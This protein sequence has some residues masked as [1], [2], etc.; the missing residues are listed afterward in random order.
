MKDNI[1]DVKVELETNEY[2]SVQ[3]KA[4]QQIHFEKKGDEIIFYKL[5]V[6]NKVGIATLK[7]KATCGNQSAYQQIELDVR[8]PNPEMATSSQTIINPSKTES[9]KIDFKNIK[10]TNKAIIELSNVPPIN[11]DQRLTYLIQYPHGCI[12]QT[13][14]SVFPQLYLGRLLDIDI[15]SQQKI[16]LNIK[17]AIQRI[18]L[19]QT[20]SGGFSYWP[21]ESEASEYGSNYAG[22]FL[23]EAEKQGYVIPTQLKNKWIKYQ[24]Q[25]AKNWVQNQYGY[26]RYESNELIQAYRLYTLTLCGSADLASMNRLR[27][28]SNICAAAKSL[29]ALAYQQIGQVE[30]AKQLIASASWQ[31]KT[32][33][34]LSYSYGSDVRDKAI[35]LMAFNKLKERKSIEKY[36][37][38]LAV[39]LNSKTWYS[40]QETAYLLLSLCEF[41]GINST[42]KSNYSYQLNNGKWTTISNTKVISKLSFNEAEIN[43]SSILSIKN[44]GTIKMYVKLVVK[45]VAMIGDTNVSNKNISLQVTY[46]NLKNEI[47]NPKA[48]K[49]GTDFYA[50]V[51][52]KN[53]N[54]KSAIKEMCLNEIFPSGWEIHNSRFLDDI[55]V[56]DV[57]Y[58]DIKDDRV[59]SYFDIEASGTQTVIIKLNATYVGKFYM[60]S[61]YSEAMYDNMIHANS[62]PMWV[63][64]LR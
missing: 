4:Q 48:I 46:K 64:V 24:Q 63:E 25:Q 37:D 33:K 51:V 1:K 2:F 52:V 55:K 60:P 36:A 59:Y 22:H 13:T 23:I 14:S 34:E 45:G 32:Y 41:Y 40:T 12:E 17:K 61:I 30:V 53:L 47:I 29:L 42:E 39:D 7:I 38:E 62:K 8:M 20:Y 10:G 5:K 15:A 49:Q 56:K 16:A 26:N 21:N 44:N 3:D 11:L 31:Q 35:L 18:Q 58:Q 6:A 9:I 27:E 43:S 19:F 28:Q 54:T 57:R 50:E